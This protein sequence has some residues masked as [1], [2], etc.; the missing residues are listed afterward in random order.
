M[1]LGGEV[2]YLRTFVRF[3]FSAAVHQQTLGIERQEVMLMYQRRKEE[4]DYEVFEKLA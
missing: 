3:L 4:R 1:N 2:A